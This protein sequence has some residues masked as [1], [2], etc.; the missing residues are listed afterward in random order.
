ME[1]TDADKRQLA[2]WRD[3]HFNPTD[4]GLR[5][6]LIGAEDQTAQP[7]VAFCDL[8]TATV[9]QIHIDRVRAEPDQAP[10]LRVLPNLYYRAVPVAAELPPFLEILSHQ[11][12]ASNHLPTAGQQVFA[13]AVLELFIAPHCPHCPQ[14]V[15]SLYPL[16]LSNTLIRLDIID[17]TLFSTRAD[18]RQIRA[19]PTL[20]LDD[21]IRWTGTVDPAEIVEVLV[22]RDPSRI[23]AASME[24]L[25]KQGDAGRL[26]GLM[27]REGKIFPRFIE[28]AVHAK[29]PVRLGAMVVIEELVAKN[30]RLAAQLIDPL[31]ERYP[32]LD[33]A[34]KGDLLHIFGEAGDDRTLPLLDQVRAQV[35][36]PELLEAVEEAIAKIKGKN[37]NGHTCR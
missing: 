33:D 29:W 22:K 6:M 28:L 5:L 25:I 11:A 1:P 15:Q 23:S 36:D 32:T 31:W 17:G 10:A 24:S 16:A 30:A 27:H 20:I 13:P 18:A 37:I 3:N 35:T 8:L 4:T 7:L 2:A 9:P 26:A 34:I 19:V 21:Y 12:D 14:A